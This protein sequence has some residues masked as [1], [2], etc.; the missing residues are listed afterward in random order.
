MH[1]KHLNV[2]YKIFMNHSYLS[3]PKILK[4][5]RENTLEILYCLNLHEASSRNSTDFWWNGS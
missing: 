3:S 1:N 5:S 2:F 4:K